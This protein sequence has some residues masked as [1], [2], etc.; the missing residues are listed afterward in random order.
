MIAEIQRGQIICT[1]ISYVH[2]YMIG[3]KG[4]IFIIIRYTIDAYKVFEFDYNLK[5]YL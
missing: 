1:T 5:Q 2:A 4:R 3:F